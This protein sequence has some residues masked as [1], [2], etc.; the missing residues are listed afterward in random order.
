MLGW[1]V[2]SQT[3]QALR[4]GALPSLDVRRV[5][6]NGESQSAGRLTTYYNSIDPLHR[7]IDG[8]VYYDRGGPLRDG[9]ADEGDQC[10]D[11]V[12][13]PQR[14]TYA[15]QREPPALGGRR[16]SHVSLPTCATST[17]SPGATRACP[18]R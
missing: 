4:D 3:V 10:R 1:D 5:I 2:F 16:A 18:R 14:P 6:A 11:R 15:R 12:R 8:I 7:V 13:Q 17:P 9:L